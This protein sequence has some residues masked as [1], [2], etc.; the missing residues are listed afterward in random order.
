MGALTILRDL[1]ISV[2][3][4]VS[5]NRRLKRR[6]EKQNEIMNEIVNVYSERHLAPSDI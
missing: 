3:N 6:K 2:K 1:R 5:M 4:K